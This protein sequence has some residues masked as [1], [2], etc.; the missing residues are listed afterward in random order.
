MPTKWIYN[1]NQQ[2]R[3]KAQVGSHFV[4]VLLY[5]CTRCLDPFECPFSRS[6]QTSCLKALNLTFVWCHLTNRFLTSQSANWRRT[7]N[8]IYPGNSISPL[9]WTD[10]LAYLGMKSLIIHQITAGRF[11]MILLWHQQYIIAM[12]NDIQKDGGLNGHSSQIFN[13]INISHQI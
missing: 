4:D 12:F 5:W 13:L 2:E 10:I 1:G 11:E 7:N 9:D 6:S 3:K 8:S